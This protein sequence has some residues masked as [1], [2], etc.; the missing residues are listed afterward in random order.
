MPDNLPTGDTPAAGAPLADGVLPT[1]PGKPDPAALT[2]E[3]AERLIDQ[4]LANEAARTHLN[5]R[6]RQHVIVIVG[7]WW[8]NA[9]KLASLGALSSGGAVL[10]AFLAWFFVVFDR[11]AV[12]T[13][14]IGAVKDQLTTLVDK[15]VDRRLK[16]DND[17]VEYYRTLRTSLT[18]DF[19][20]IRGGLGAIQ[21]TLS[22]HKALAGDVERVLKG[23]P[24]D[25][26]ELDKEI[27]SSNKKLPISMKYTMNLIRRSN[28]STK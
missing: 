4:I 20:E 25:L 2:V 24:T 1:T 3:Q 18:S 19:G 10:V 27:E 15:E 7:D 13:E 21:G 28:L 11:N 26:R 23:V 12:K 8:K 5:A 9:T 6:L 14:V 17:L 22:S 16:A